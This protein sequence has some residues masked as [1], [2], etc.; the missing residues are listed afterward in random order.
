MNDIL[1]YGSYLGWTLH[2]DGKREVWVANRAGVEMNAAHQAML[3]SM[4]DQRHVEEVNRK[5]G[6]AGWIPE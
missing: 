1:N 4:I 5:R 6:P 2:W 3:K